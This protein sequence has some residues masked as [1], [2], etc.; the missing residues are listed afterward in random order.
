MDRKTDVWSE[1]YPTLKPKISTYIHLTLKYI[2]YIKKGHTY[3]TILDTWKWKSD[4]AASLSILFASSTKIN[5]KWP[6]EA[7]GRSE[8]TTE[9]VTHYVP[10]I[11]YFTDSFTPV[12]LALISHK[13]N[14]TS[15]SNSFLET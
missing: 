5:I 13:R 6:L 10:K 9:H 1:S 14:A 7:Q 4:F 15:G 8:I 2:L 3:A 12:N 11:V